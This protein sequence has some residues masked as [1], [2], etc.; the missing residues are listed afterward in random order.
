[1]HEFIS[2]SSKEID[3]NSFLSGVSQFLQNRR[4]TL[5]QTFETEI[6]IVSTLTR[7]DLAGSVM[8]IAVVGSV[9]TDSAV[10]LIQVKS[11]R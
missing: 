9:C 2:S 10:N 7:F 11:L 6:D 5:Q 1:M 4:T 8:G 3:Y